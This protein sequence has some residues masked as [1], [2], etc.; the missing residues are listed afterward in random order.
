MK[1]E[2]KQWGRIIGFVVAVVAVAVVASV[3]YQIGFCPFLGKIIAGNKLAA[4]A[5]TQMQRTDPVKAQFDWYNGRYVC[6]FN[7]DS[8][9]SYRLQNNTIHD[10]AANIR[11]NAK[12]REI[13]K[14]IMSQFPD[15]LTFPEHIMVWSTVNADDYAIKAERLYLLGVYNTDNLSD[16][17]SHDMP[18]KIAIDSITLMGDNFNI[19]GIQLI[20]ADRNGM[21]DIEIRADSFQ[22]LTQQQ[23]LAATQKRPDKELPYSYREW[24]QDNNFDRRKQEGLK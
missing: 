17:E 15:N 22:P 18:A 8:V 1:Q 23:L 20:Y 21:Y 7:D 14:G 9:L 19:T 5:N 11:L 24:L 10:E 13:Y 3:F 4:Y 12:V 16:S 6:S 2:N